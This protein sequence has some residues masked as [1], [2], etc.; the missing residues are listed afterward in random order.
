MHAQKEYCKVLETKGIHILNNLV[1]LI[2]LKWIYLNSGLND[3]QY[4]DVKW[5]VGVERESFQG[6]VNDESLWNVLW[7]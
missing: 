6:F 4:K 7:C 3:T 1:L 2:V 5:G